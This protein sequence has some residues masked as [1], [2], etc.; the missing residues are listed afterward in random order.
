MVLALKSLRKTSAS[1]P[2][3]RFLEY[4]GNPKGGLDATLVAKN[5]AA[6]LE[7]RVAFRRALKKAMA[8]GMKFGAKG[9]KISASG[10]LGGA[11]MGRFER[12]RRTNCLCTRF[13]RTLTM[14]QQLRRRNT[15]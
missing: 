7:R 9:F 5:V 1:T 11:E 13:V 12:Y 3:A 6:Q 14:E 8:T 2:P 4:P 10:R 15:A